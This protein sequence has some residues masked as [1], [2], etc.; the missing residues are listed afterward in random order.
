MNLLV[1]AEISIVPFI[2][3]VNETNLR[4][5]FITRVMENVI[6]ENERAR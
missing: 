6:L 5:I 2:C 1:L 3:A 4:A